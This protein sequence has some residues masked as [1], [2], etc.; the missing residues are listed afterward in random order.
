[1]A[2]ITCPECGEQY[3]DQ[4]AFCPGCGFPTPAPLKCAECGAVLTGAESVCRC[5]G[6]PVESRAAQAAPITVPMQNPA[7]AAVTPSVNIGQSAK[8]KFIFLN[9]YAL[10]A[11]IP[12]TIIMFGKIFTIK[13]GDREIRSFGIKEFSDF[14]AILSKITGGLNIADEF[15]R[16]TSILSMLRYVFY[17]AAIIS[18]IAFLAGWFKIGKD[19]PL[20]TALAFPAAYAAG[21]LILIIAMNY[22]AFADINKFLSNFGESKLTMWFSTDFVPVFVFAVIGA[23]LEFTA[24]NIECQRNS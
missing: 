17:A 2:T 3:D 21:S 6:A 12:T 13:F 15:T 5:C 14:N 19:K 16:V 8:P 23:I 18:A 1:M 22:Y 20:T 9:I 4:A 7:P 24:Q 11:L 10:L